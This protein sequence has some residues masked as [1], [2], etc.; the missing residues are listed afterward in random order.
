MMENRL[1]LSGNL[2]DLGGSIFVSNDDNEQSALKGCLDFVF[3]P[4]NFVTQIIWQKKYSPQNDA[5]YLSDN[6]DYIT[7]FARQK[8]EWRRNLLPRT[9]EANARYSN[10]DNDPRGLWKPSGLD[11]K[12]YSPEYDYPITTPSGRVVKPPRG[13]CWRTSKERLQELIADNRI[14]FGPEGNSVPALKRFLSEVQEGMVPLTIWTYQEVGHNQEAIQHLKAIMGEFGDVFQTPK[15]AR[16]L[17]RCFQIGANS[18]STIL[19]FFAGSGTTGHAVINLNREDGGRRKFILVEMAQYFDTV[20]L[21]RI[22]KVTFTPEWKDGKPKRMATAEEAERSPRIVKVIRLESYEDALNNLSF[23]QES[24]PKALDLFRDDYL[25]SYM[26]RWETRHSETLLNVEQL[27]APFSYKL[28]LHRDGETRERTVDLPETFAYLLGLD[29]QTRRVYDD[30]GRRYL[31]Y[32]GTLRNSCTVAV[33]WRDTKDWKE[34]EKDYRR[35]RDF[36][37]KQ[38]LVEGADKIYTNGDSIIPGACSLDGLFKAR[39]FAPVEA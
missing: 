13:R 19:D 22:K 7:L 33:I 14:W 28:R 5:K 32:R 2:F 21:P 35:E 10:P 17:Q 25:L 31:V 3:G 23:D 1:R 4:E 16:L 15:P 34:K 18:D 24:G 20:L 29:V 6:H 37:E 38:K 36:V 12:T 26:L 27:Q 39:M 30:E 8:E 9:E 11:V